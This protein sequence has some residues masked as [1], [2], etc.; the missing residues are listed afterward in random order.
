[1]IVLIIL[2]DIF[3]S[4]LVTTYEVVVEVFPMRKVRMYHID[5]RTHKQALSKAKKYGR[6][7]SANK[8]DAT[9]FLSSIETLDLESVTV[10]PVL[11]NPYENALAMDEFIWQK[12]NVRINNQ[13]RDKPKE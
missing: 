11:G 5:A 7:K 13:Y 1:M 3:L 6:P 4:G 10:E 12:R 2:I 8:V 9:R